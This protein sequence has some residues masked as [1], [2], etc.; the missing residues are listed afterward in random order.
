VEL[1]L[2]DL[3]PAGGREP[4]LVDDIIST[5]ATMRQAVTLLRNAGFPA[6][7]CVAVHPVFA[8]DAERELMRAGAH[9]VVTC[10]TLA[11]PT[12]GID[13]LPAIVEGVRVLLAA[14]PE[15]ALAASR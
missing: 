2:P 10:N 4:V 11:H 6:P 13:V 5:G 12:N 9:S 15:P 8:G 1:R 14:D 7:R 3:G